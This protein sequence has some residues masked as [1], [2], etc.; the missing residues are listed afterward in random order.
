MLQ[1]YNPRSSTGRSAIKKK[2]VRKC[3]I[4]ILLNGYRIF[5]TEFGITK[6]GKPYIFFLIN[7][8]V[9]LEEKLQLSSG[10]WT[11]RGGCWIEEVTGTGAWNKRSTIKSKMFFTLLA[12]VRVVAYCAS[13][14]QNVESWYVTYVCWEMVAINVQLICWRKDG[15]QRLPAKQTFSSL[16]QIIC[17][18]IPIGSRCKILFSSCPF[19]ENS[20]W[21]KQ[22]W[23]WTHIL[24]TSRNQIG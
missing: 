6:K 7:I 4:A 10:T 14:S 3:L 23:E 9:K 24:R 21:I 8:D 18:L 15:I 13:A 16:I 12:H 19:V 17:Y 2:P 11:W 5:G 20:F 22:L 1:I